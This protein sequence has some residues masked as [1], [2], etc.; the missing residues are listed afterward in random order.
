MKTLSGADLEWFWAEMAHAARTAQPLHAALGELAKAN[1]GTRRGRAAERIAGAMSSGKS[2]PQAVA[3][4]GAFPFGA[5]E[6]LE[7]GERGGRLEEVFESLSESARTEAYFRLSITHA[8]IYPAV[9]AVAALAVAMFMLT[10]IMPLFEQ[11]FKE[12]NLEMPV[13]TKLALG[14]FV[15]GAF[16]L[17]TVPALMLALLYVVPPRCLPFR[18]VCDGLRLNLPLL[19]EVLRRFLLA[20]WCGAMSLLVRAGVPEPQ[21]VRLAGRSTGHAGVEALSQWLA[22]ELEKGRPLGEAMEEKRFFPPPLV[23][24]VSSSQK[25]GGHAGVWPAAQDL[26]RTQGER[27]SY[28]ASVILRVAFIALAFLMVMVTVAALF[29]PLVRLMQ[30][31][32]G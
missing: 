8:I 25:I 27:L 29:L 3:E 19:G 17:L 24:M 30:S 4:D 28:V 14:G 22:G 20:R 15:T 32:G 18:W 21:A 7:S 5:A 11:M 26:Y 31:L 16:V 1:P 6:A 12:M 13:L 10:R 23:W 2:L 9:I